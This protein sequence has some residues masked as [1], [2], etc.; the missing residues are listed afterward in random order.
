[1]SFGAS[2]GVVVYDFKIKNKSRI[3]IGVLCPRKVTTLPSVRVFVRLLCEDSKKTG[4]NCLR[5]GTSMVYDVR[6]LL[7]QKK[8]SHVTFTCEL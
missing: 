8:N 4:P 6:V 3:F 7:A 5:E 2:F 1:V